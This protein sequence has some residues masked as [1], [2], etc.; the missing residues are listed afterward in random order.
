MEYT[1]HNVRRASRHHLPTRHQDDARR[2]PE[3]RDMVFSIQRASP[4][5]SASFR[6]SQQICERSERQ[7]SKLSKVFS[8][9]QHGFARV[10]SAT[11]VPYSCD[12]TFVLFESSEREISKLSKLINDVNQSLLSIAEQAS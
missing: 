4:A 8:S 9:A 7:I 10:V 12:S 11:R 6:P 1:A 5:C 2:V 3:L